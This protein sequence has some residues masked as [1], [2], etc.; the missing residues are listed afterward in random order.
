MGQESE[1]RSRFRGV[2]VG[3]AYGEALASGQRFSLVGPIARWS[4]ATADGLI[5]S[6][7][8]EQPG[9]KNHVPIYVW[10]G[11]LRWLGQLR[12]SSA[13]AIACESERLG[14]LGAL[15]AEWPPTAPWLA[16]MDD[17][18]DVASRLSEPLNDLVEALCVARFA[19][20]AV[21]VQNPFPLGAHLAMLTHGSELACTTT[22][23]FC[24][25]VQRLVAGAGLRTAIWDTIDEAVAVLAPEGHLSAVHEVVREDWSGELLGPAKVGSCDKLLAHSIANVMAREDVLDVSTARIFPPEIRGEMGSVSG[26]LLGALAGREAFAHDGVLSESGLNLMEDVADD[27]FDVVFPGAEN[28]PL[29]L[30]DLRRRYP[31]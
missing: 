18:A 1:V 31:M 15:P 5:R 4:L 14:W 6:V 23:V 29:R 19:P 24:S 30:A 21:F 12:P 22:S 17:D 16:T 9:R 26:C 25:I 13:N 10:D 28:D 8:W 3:T 7:L 11:Y 27:L 20:A 2:L